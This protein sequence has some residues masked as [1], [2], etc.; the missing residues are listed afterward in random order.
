ML[1]FSGKTNMEK[2]YIVTT[3]Q[4]LESIATSI[5]AIKVIELMAYHLLKCGQSILSKTIENHTKQTRLN[6]RDNSMCGIKFYT[7]H[8]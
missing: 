8:D 4:R 3:V 7:F 6:A 1:M 2:A 5:G